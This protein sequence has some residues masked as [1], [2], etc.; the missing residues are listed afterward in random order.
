M[1]KQLLTMY[2]SFGILLLSMGET[3][4]DEGTEDHEHFFEYNTPVMPFENDIFFPNIGDI[5]API[6]VEFFYNYDCVSCN[7]I[8]NFLLQRQ[9][10]NNDS[11]ITFHPI[12]QDNKEFEIAMLEVLS[13][14]EGRSIF[15]AIHQS[16][17]MNLDKENFSLQFTL[18]E[19]YQFNPSLALNL[20]DKFKNESAFRLGLDMSAEIAKRAGVKKLPTL[21]INNVIID[22]TDNL[23]ELERLIII[24]KTKVLQEKLEQTTRELSKNPL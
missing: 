13:F 22:D 23:E 24:E 11:R 6:M 20:F 16:L 18:G 8:S 19:I 3:L 15:E 4:A 17:M 1:K 14:T 9:E 5:D 10:K 21:I 12:P 2:L 7:E